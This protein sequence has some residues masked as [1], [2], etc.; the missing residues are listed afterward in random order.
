MSRCAVLLDNSPSVLSDQPVLIVDADAS[1]R[2][3][4]ATMFEFDGWRVM[5]AQDGN[6]G[7]TVALK[8]NPWAAVVG[9]LRAR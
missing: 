3:M 5:E 2:T 1:V 8:V 6:E 9:V 7:L 4:L